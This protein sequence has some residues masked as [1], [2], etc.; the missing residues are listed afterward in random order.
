MSKL[1]QF[2]SAFKS[3]SKAVYT[4]THIPIERV[5]VVTDLPAEPSEVFLGEVKNFLHALGTDDEVVSWAGHQVQPG[6]GADALLEV[7]ESNRP[8]LVCCFRNLQ[9]RARHFPFSLGAHV[10]VLAQATTTAILLMPEPNESG[11]L[12]ANLTRATNVMVLTDH[13]TGAAHLIDH[14]VRFTPKDGVLV[15]AHLEDDATFERYMATIGKI[16][17]IETEEAR[18][19]IHAQL[20]KEP[21]DYIRSV[22]QVLKDARVDIGT[23]EEVCM[24]HRV[25]DCNT[26][27][28]QHRV[29]LL[30][31]NTKDDDQ[32]AMHGLAYPIAVELR[33]TPLLLL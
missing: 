10:D 25:S 4:H 20:T 27:V 31:M 30:V 29:D 33:A 5:L 24:G 17:A 26:L 7:I 32:L 6:D 14:G 3:A 13:L 9:G 8:D 12:S 1:D 23:Q 19:L 2:E 18:Q 22:R 11:R 28:E 16:P 15:L 21:Q